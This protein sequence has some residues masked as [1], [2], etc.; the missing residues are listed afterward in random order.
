MKRIAVA[1]L[2]FYSFWALGSMISVLVGVP[3][4]LGPVL[5]LMAGAIVGLDPRHLIWSHPV[6]RTP[7]AA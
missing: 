5:G 3:D 1:A 2:W 7:A 4:F 6:Q